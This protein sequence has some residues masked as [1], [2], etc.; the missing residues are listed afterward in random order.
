ME[1]S[2]KIGISAFETA[3]QFV[4]ISAFQRLSLHNGFEIFENLRDCRFND[5]TI[6][7]SHAAQG[8]I[9]PGEYLI[10]SI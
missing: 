8:R 4:S 7:T 3:F 5:V 6:L 9:R 1:P 10:Q 2:F